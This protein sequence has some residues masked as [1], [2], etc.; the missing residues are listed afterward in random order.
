M[1]KLIGY[2]FFIGLAA[3]NGAY[4]CRN[5]RHVGPLGFLGYLSI[6]ASIAA[7]IAGILAANSIRSEED[8]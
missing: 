8:N 2:L 6:V 5:L 4:V 7:T 3:L 1:G